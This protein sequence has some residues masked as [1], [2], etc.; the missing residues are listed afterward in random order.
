MSCVSNIW[1]WRILNNTLSLGKPWEPTHTHTHTHTHTQ[2]CRKRK[3]NSSL[4]RRGQHSCLFFF[5]PS[6]TC[7]HNGIQMLWAKCFCLN[8]TNASFKP[9]I[10]EGGCYT[11]KTFVREEKQTNRLHTDQIQTGIKSVLS[12]RE[13]EEKVTTKQE[14]SNNEKHLSKWGTDSGW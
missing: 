2:T 4:E 3:R 13:R 14:W 6:F 7:L 9:H 12:W 1:V 10:S 5:S 8:D 11:R